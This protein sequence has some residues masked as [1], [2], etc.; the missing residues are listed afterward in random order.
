L[1]LALS[2][3]G[4]KVAHQIFVGIAQNIITISAV[5]TKSQFFT[6]K[7]GDQVG[8]G[9]TISL[10]LPNLVT[11]LKSGILV[12]LLASAIGTMIFLFISSHMVVL[13]FKATISLK[14]APLGIVISA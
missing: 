14:L 10:P 6:F 2:T 5:F 7:Y 1:N 13:P 3:F 8:Q 9:S 12:N 4:G 11:S